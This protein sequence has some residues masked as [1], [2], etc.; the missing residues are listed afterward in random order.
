MSLSSTID[1]QTCQATATPKE[2]AEML[3]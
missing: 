3:G 2:V 1:I